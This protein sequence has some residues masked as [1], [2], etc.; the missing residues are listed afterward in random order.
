MT[1]HA[2]E[3][4]NVRIIVNGAPVLIPGIT[5]S[6][7]YTADRV[8]RTTG[9]PIPT[10]YVDVLT[11]HD[12]P[13]DQSR[14]GNAR[15][16]WKMQRQSASFMG[17]RTNAVPELDDLTAEELLAH[18]EQSLA[19]IQSATVRVR[20]AVI[21]NAADAVKPKAVF[22]APAPVLAK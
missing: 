17:Y 4:V 21:E 7:E 12:V 6:D 19:E 14:S 8:S 11:F 2:N 3:A 1:F 10:Q 20:A 5:A 18:V 9:S 16:Y 22:G 13:A 15:K